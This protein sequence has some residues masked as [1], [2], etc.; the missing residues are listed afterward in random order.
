MLRDIL[1]C[2][3]VGALFNI[4]WALTDIQKLLEAMP[5]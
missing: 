2:V 5:K 3:I 4:A 1:L